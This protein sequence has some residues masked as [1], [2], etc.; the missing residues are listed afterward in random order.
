M[1][2]IRYKGEKVTAGMNYM[3]I[4]NVKRVKAAYN[5]LSWQN[6]GIY[7]SL[8]VNNDERGTRTLGMQGIMGLAI[9][10][11]TGLG[12]LVAKDILKRSP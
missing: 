10:R 2:F 12:Y 3:Y 11:H 7:K 6:T 5:T 1:Q 8:V 4:S 9:P